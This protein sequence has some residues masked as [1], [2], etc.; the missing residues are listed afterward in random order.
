MSV[1]D[2]SMLTRKQPEKAL[3]HG[4]MRAVGRNHHGRITTRHKGGGHKRRYREVDFG[5]DKRDIPARIISFEYD[6]NRS[7]F[8]ALVCYRDGEKRYVLLPQNVAVGGEIITSENAPIQPGNRLPLKKIPAGTFVYNIELKPGAG[9]RVARS[10]GVGVEVLSHDA[11]LA[12]LKLPSKEVR[13]VSGECW[14]SVGKLAK[15]EHRFVSGGKAGRSRWRGIRPTVRGSAMNPVDHPYGGGEG[16][17][18]RGTRRPKN[19]W[20]KGTRGVKTRNPKKYSN[21]L[22]VEKRK[23]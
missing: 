1:V 3:T 22:I 12:Q 11:G 6:P 10:A 20:G 17:A 21:Y 13:L 7:S 8:I 16:R 5:A 19:L 15:E 9:A 4:F 14:A 2:M 23:K 18:M